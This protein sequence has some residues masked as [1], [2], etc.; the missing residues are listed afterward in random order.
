[1]RVSK[2]IEFDAGHRVPFHASK[3]KHP[4]GHRY[5][6]KAVL[7]GNLVPDD[8]MVNDSG[9]VMD[10]AHIKRILTERVHDIYDHSFVYMK[11]DEVGMAL[12]EIS[13]SIIGAE[14]RVFEVDF[15]PTAENFARHIYHDL[16]P[17]FVSIYGNTLFLE[18]I[19]IYET[20]TSIAEYDIDDFIEERGGA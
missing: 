10:F 17:Q 2:E 20:P 19:I 6:V 5:K 3:C 8:A 14:A 11:G 15:I 18:R 4:H 9:M 7:R 1:M 13:R 12:A 16:H